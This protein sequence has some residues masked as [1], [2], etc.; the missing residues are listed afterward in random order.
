MGKKIIDFKMR[1]D[2]SRGRNQFFMQKYNEYRLI[3]IFY[4]QKNIDKKKK[5]KSIKEKNIC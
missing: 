1:R 5:E 4:Q 3:I 2:A